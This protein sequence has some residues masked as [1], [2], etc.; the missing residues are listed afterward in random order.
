MSAAGRALGVFGATV[1]HAVRILIHREHRVLHPPADR[2]CAVDCGAVST[3]VSRSLWLRMLR[4]VP[5]RQSW[6]SQA[7]SPRRMASPRGVRRERRSRMCTLHRPWTSL[8]WASARFGST[9]LRVGR[10]GSPQVAAVQLGHR[11]ATES[12]SCVARTS[13]STIWGPRTRSRSRLSVTRSR[14][15]G[16]EP[17]GRYYFGIGCQERTSRVGCS[18][19]RIPS[20]R[21]WVHRVGRLTGGRRARSLSTV[22]RTR[23]G[24]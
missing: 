14:H 10:L 18:I 2:D 8:I 9:T 5:I 4:H 22:R 3:S 19:R 1:T 21:I 7:G 23:R 6:P 11:L 13:G 17:R 15:A 16:I 20:Q 24:S 12:R